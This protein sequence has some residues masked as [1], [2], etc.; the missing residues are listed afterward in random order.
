MSLV[1]EIL[2]A[3]KIQ[4]ISKRKSSRTDLKTSFKAGFYPFHFGSMT[5]SRDLADSQTSMK[6]I[7]AVRISSKLW[8]RREQRYQNHR[9]SKST[10]RRLF[11]LGPQ[12]IIQRRNNWDGS[13]QRSQRQWRKVQATN[14]KL[15]K[16]KFFSSVT[17]LLSW[18]KK[19]LQNISWGQDCHS[20]Q[21]QA[22]EL[23]IRLKISYKRI[24]KYFKY[25]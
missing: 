4:C 24:S 2:L 5:C 7:S 15:Q 20:S 3:L 14:R 11:R 22:R 21:H 19:S 13:H 25:F 10:W 16:P 1:W 9:T 18:T 8:K 12:N 23:A 17:Q 6:S